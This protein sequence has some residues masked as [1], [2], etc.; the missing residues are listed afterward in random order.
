MEATLVKV[1]TCL[2]PGMVLATIVLG[3]HGFLLRQI[4]FMK[5]EQQWM[6]STHASLWEMCNHCLS[7]TN[8]IIDHARCYS[9]PWQY[10]TPY[11][12]INMYKLHKLKN[13]TG[14]PWN[15]LRMPQIYHPPVTT[16]CLNNLKKHWEGSGMKLIWGYK[17]HAHWLQTCPSSFLKEDIQK[18]SCTEKM[19]FMSLCINM[20]Y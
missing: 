6:L 10:K 15:T 19:C 20:I 2:S 18:L 13:L 5:G 11:H 16:T 4:F 12:C 14:C 8:D 17:V 3:F 7:M 1:K 9:S